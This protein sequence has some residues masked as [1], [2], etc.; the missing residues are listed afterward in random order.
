M[1][2]PK[3]CDEQVRMSGNILIQFV[4]SQTGKFHFWLG[5]FDI[6]TKEHALFYGEYARTLGNILI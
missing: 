1:L 2:Q 3:I 4:I 5:Q 6:T